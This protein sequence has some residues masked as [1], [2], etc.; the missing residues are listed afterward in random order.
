MT[1]FDVVIISVTGLS[2]FFDLS[3]RRIPNWLIVFGLAA[4]MTL[5]SYQGL[6]Q[7][8]HSALGFVVGIAALIIPFAFGWM[9]A[10]DVK[11]FGVLGALFG[12]SWLPR[13]FFYSALVAGVIAL[14]Y[15]I[16][17]HFNFSF[18][19]NAW[20][21]IKVAVM[22]MG[23]VFPAPISIGASK[24]ARSVPWGVAFTA[25]ALVAYYIDRGGQWAGF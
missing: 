14:G 17:G 9:G 16:A 18:F 2:V 12:V 23:S 11:Y 1:A 19:K 3:A 10:G 21:D 25:G 22:S 13:V 6:N 7:L 15:M 20:G 4:G 5:H 24:P 8:S